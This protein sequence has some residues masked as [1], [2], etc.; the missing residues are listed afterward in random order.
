MLIR[1]IALLVLAL[2]GVPAQPAQYPPWFRDALELGRTHDEA[3]FA[4]F[5][6]GYS[7]SPSGIIDAAEVITEFRRAV[8]IVREHALQGDFGFG[9]GDLDKA[10]APYR[11]LVTFIVQ[12][13]LN[14]LNTFMTPPPYDLYVST[15]PQTPPVAAKS[16]KRDPVYP[17]GGAPGSQVVGVRLEA[18]FPRNAIVS[19]PDPRLIVTDE[20]AE[21]IWQAHLD[22]SRYR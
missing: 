18:S 9:P 11:G 16:F 6:K 20:K 12:V 7:L 10:L 4:S 21:I 22:L 1:P 19:A 17:P 3:L 2:A 14:P 15:G 5:N 13:R 8:L